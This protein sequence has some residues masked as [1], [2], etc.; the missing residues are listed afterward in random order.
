MKSPRRKLAVIVNGAEESAAAVRARQLLIALGPEWEVRLYYRQASRRASLFYFVQNLLA[1]RPR[2]IYL[3]DSALPGALAV[4]ATFG[5]LRAK[6]VLDTGDL[7]Y[8]LARATGL[9]QGWRLGLIGLTEKAILRAASRIIV[10]GSFYRQWLEERGYRR[11]SFLPDGVDCD[12]FRPCTGPEESAALD[13]LQAELGLGRDFVVGTVGSSVWS[14]RLGMAYGW[15]LLEA[16]ALLPDLPMRGL[17]IARGDGLDYLR[18]RT[19]ELGLGHRLTLIEGVPHEKLPLYLNLMDVCLSTQTNNSVGWVRTTGK[20][21]EYLACGRFVLAS[22]VGEASR[23]LQP[24]PNMLLPYQGGTRDAD[25]PT[26]L[27]ERI[28]ELATDPVRAY[29]EEAATLPALARREFDYRVLREG[30]RDLFES[31]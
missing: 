31:L 25:Y 10:R 26:R 8:E 6:I 11:V 13:E 5:L 23:V 12:R 30:F 16:L 28:R 14:G 21:P 22:A 18:R 4:L 27:A 29:Q 7:G 2:L 17:I 19:A 3:V 1:Y 24:Y 20:L 15:D 9:A